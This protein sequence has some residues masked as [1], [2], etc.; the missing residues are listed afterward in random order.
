MMHGKAVFTGWT[1]VSGPAAFVDWL[2]DRG[3]AVSY[4]TF[5]SNVDLSDFKAEY[6]RLGISLAKDDQITW[7]RSEL[8]DGSTV[9]VMQYSGIEHLF[10]RPDQDWW[11]T[12]SAI[13]D[14][15]DLL[16]DGGWPNNW[17][18]EEIE[19]ALASVA[20]EGA[21][22]NPEEAGWLFETGVPV[23]FRYMRNTERSPY[24]GATFG[25][26]IEPAGRFFLADT[27]NAADHPVRGWEYGWATFQCPLVLLF[28]TEPD[29]PHYGPH[30]WKARLAAEFG[31]TG[32]K[33][34][35]K[36]RAAGYDGIVTIWEHGGR[37]DYTKEIV[38]LTFGE[39]L[40]PDTR[41]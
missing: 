37:F 29:L 6:R 30:G 19:A 2:V 27:A 12:R 20:E 4:R 41:G 39:A 21:Q 40:T 28:T 13:Q 7:L 35:R 9:W 33:L 23:T 38:D 26:D 18:W 32:K 25:Q 24:F 3:T 17:T 8:L 11:Y 31:A 1:C 15:T 34:T 36:L 5:A 10:A 16:E 22:R 14:V